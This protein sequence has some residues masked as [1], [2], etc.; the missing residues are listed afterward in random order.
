MHSVWQ[1]TRVFSSGS[2]QNSSPKSGVLNPGILD[3]F[4]APGGGFGLGGHG[5]ACHRGVSGCPSALGVASGLAGHQ[6]QPCASPAGLAA[7]TGVGGENGCLCH[8]GERRLARRVTSPRHGGL[9]GS[10]RPLSPVRSHLR[11]RTSAPG[12]TWRRCGTRQRGCWPNCRRPSGAIA[13]NNKPSRCVLG[14]ESRTGHSHHWFFP[15]GAVGPSRT[16][17]TPPHY[18]EGSADT[19]LSQFK[20]DTP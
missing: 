3:C 8:A 5:P 17:K 19:N 13:W 7:A 6:R 4:P 16:P 14:R 15:F 12:R 10:C 2:D 1:Q 20:N 9:F 11:R 18:P